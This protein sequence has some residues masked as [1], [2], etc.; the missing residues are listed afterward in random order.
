MYNTKAEICF[1]GTRS[2]LRLLHK[3]LKTEEKA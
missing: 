1:G 2:S 3:P